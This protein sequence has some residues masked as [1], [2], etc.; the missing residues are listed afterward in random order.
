MI[1]G[2]RQPIFAT[3][4][5]DNNL[6]W[7]PTYICALY[8]PE[9]RGLQDVSDVRVWDLSTYHANTERDDVEQRLGRSAPVLHNS[10]SCFSQLLRKRYLCHVIFYR[11]VASESLSRQNDAA[12]N[13]Y[14]ETS[15][16][17]ANVLL[18]YKW[19]MQPSC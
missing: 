11:S 19:N 15:I 1:E 5:P 2:I 7:R 18:T 3:T 4:V 13:T 12:A 9:G 16:G 8:I 17:A 10:P 14:I 6:Y